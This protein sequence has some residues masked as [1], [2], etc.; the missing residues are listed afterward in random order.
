LVQHNTIYALSAELG[1]L[2]WQVKV[3]PL[4]KA[5]STVAVDSSGPNTSALESASYLT[6]Y[7]FLNLKQ[8]KITYVDM[9]RFCFGWINR[10]FLV[11]HLSGWENTKV[12]IKGCFVSIEHTDITH[13]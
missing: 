5:G 12:S 3:G 13:S 10:W 9:I 11:C 2:I 4:V 7:I 6:V 1:T 8:G